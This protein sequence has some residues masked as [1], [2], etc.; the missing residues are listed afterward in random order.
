[1][2]EVMPFN[3]SL[4]DTFDVDR[5]KLTKFIYINDLDLISNLLSIKLPI[6]NKRIAL[7]NILDFLTYIDNK[8]NIKGNTLI[9]I[10]SKELIKYFNRDN[11]KEYMKILKELEIISDVPYLDG[12]FYKKG[13]LYKQYRVHN[14]YLNKENLAIIVLEDDRSKERFNNEIEGLDERYIKTIKNL[15]INVKEAIKAE[16][17]Y[18]KEKDLT[19]FNLRNRISRILYTRRRRF[20][21]KGKSVD[22]IYHSFSNVSKV[23]RK[24]INIKMFDVDIKNCQ[25]LLLVALL[26]QLNLEFDIEYKFDCEIGNFYEQFIGIKNY[27]RDDVKEQLYKNIFF[28]FN[29]N[30]IINKEFKKIYPNTWNSLSIIKE[31]NISLAS[32]LQNLESELFNNLIPKKSKHFF[33]LFDSIYFDNINDIQK[34][35]EEIN[36][37]F[38]DKGIKVQTEIGL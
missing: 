29:R 34:I 32:Q 14:E 26:K 16:M 4:F 22:R 12:T 10:S 17:E 37:F 25:P 27:T 5:I 3:K 18:Y 31:S 21:K 30:N 9:S 35:I 15:E 6:E 11:Y 36:K 2:I 7:R 8:I 19:I 24:Y 20:I 28:G 33:T 23:S 1:M 38:N 13:S